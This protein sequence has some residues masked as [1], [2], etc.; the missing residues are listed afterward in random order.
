MGIKISLTINNIPVRVSLGKK[1]ISNMN[2]VNKDFYQEKQGCFLVSPPICLYVFNQNNLIYIHRVT[3]SHPVNRKNT[4]MKNLSTLILVAIIATTTLSCEEKQNKEEA[5]HEVEFLLVQNADSVVLNNGQLRLK[6]I[7]P[8]TLYFS[9]RPDRIVG[10]ITTQ[11]YVDHW[12]VG[13]NNFKSKIP[14]RYRL[15]AYSVAIV[16]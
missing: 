4:Q 9:D 14:S 13:D 5:T 11:K 10:R 1:L 7:A 2:P 15:N 6:N 12:A 3:L 8:T 16:M